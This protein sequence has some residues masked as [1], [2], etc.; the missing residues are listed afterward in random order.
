MSE[1]LCKARHIMPVGTF[2]CLVCGSRSGYMDG[3]SNE[4]LKGLERLDWLEDEDSEDNS[5]EG[6]IID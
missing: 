2:V 6:T 1:F 3:S 5:E 4:E